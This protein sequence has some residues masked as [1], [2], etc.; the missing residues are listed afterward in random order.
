MA[1]MSPTRR[2]MV[3]ALLP[4]W[5]YCSRLVAVKGR[6]GRP[7]GQNVSMWYS[8]LARFSGPL[9]AARGCSSQCDLNMYRTDA[10]FDVPRQQCA[11]SVQSWAISKSSVSPQSVRNLAPVVNVAAGANCPNVR[12][13]QRIHVSFGAVFVFPLSSSVKRLN[14]MLD[15]VCAY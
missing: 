2:L 15:L 5:G 13:L 1:L 3:S 4:G 11:V 10:A 7:S 6:R 9:K 12:L 8:D 14:R